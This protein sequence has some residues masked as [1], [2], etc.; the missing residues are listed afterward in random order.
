[1]LAVARFGVVDCLALVWTGV[2][3]VGVHGVDD[4]YAGSPAAGAGCR[5]ALLVASLQRPMVRRSWRYATA[6]GTVGSQN[7]IRR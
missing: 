7:E 6:P 5:L 1:M 3:A 2:L 4:R